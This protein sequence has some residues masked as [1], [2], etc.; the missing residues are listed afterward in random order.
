MYKFKVVSDVG[1][2]FFIYAS[3]RTEAI[4]LFCEEKSVNQDYVKT[5]CLIKNLGRVK[6][7]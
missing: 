5:H 2:I 4:M 1:E 7:E 6:G 3:C